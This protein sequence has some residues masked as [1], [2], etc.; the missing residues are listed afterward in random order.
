MSDP[1]P[2]INATAVPRL[3]AQPSLGMPSFMRLPTAENAAGLD[4][5]LAGVPLDSR[6]TH[7]AGARHGPREIRNQ[8]GLI[9]PIHHVSGVAPYELLR[10]ADLGDAPVNPDDPSDSLQR[11]EAF[12]AGIRQA[13]AIPIA[14][15]GDSLATLPV[16]RALARNRKAGLVQF[17]AHSG[18]R[19]AFPGDPPGA[20]GGPIRRAVEEGLLDPH[21]IVQIGLR[22]ALHERSAFDYAR[23]AGFRLIFIEEVME[24]GPDHIMDETR[25]II[26]EA[27]V[28]VSFDIDCL[29]PSI[30]PGTS[31]PEIGGLTAR[32]AQRMLRRLQGASIIGADLVEVSPPFDPSGLTAL[33]GAALMFELLCAIAGGKAA[34]HGLIPGTGKPARPG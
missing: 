25:D 1:Q 32:E 5:A 23:Q 30:A 20:E 31:T 15:G 26:G 11:I 18:T 33:T 22:G 24:H 10:V 13:G 19:R 3:A 8:S 16:L 27:P 9:G 29:D 2:P 14:A 7:R 21:R 6:V 12:F 4:V 28:Y 34:R 17:D